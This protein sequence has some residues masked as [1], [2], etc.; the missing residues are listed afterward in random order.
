[1]PR[2]LSLSH[3]IYADNENLYYESER[4]KSTLFFKEHRL[5]FALTFNLFTRIHCLDFPINKRASS[6][7]FVRR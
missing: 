5:S 6:W 3:S 1:M 7:S 2:S 4:K